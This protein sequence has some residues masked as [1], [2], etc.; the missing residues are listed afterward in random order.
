MRIT[1]FQHFLD[2]SGFLPRE[3][4][5]LRLA[6]QLARIIEAATCR[7]PGETAASAVACDRRPGRRA[8][9]GFIAVARWEVPQEIRW[10]CTVCGDAGQIMGWSDTTWDLRGQRVGRSESG[11]KRLE[12]SFDRRQYRGLLDLDHLDFDSHVLLCRACSTSKGISLAASREELEFLADDIVAAANHEFRPSWAQRFRAA[13]RAIE[14]VLVSGEA[15]GRPRRAGPARL[16]AVYRIHVRLQGVRPPVWRRLEVSAGSSLGVL[17][18]TIQSSLGWEDCHLH[19]FEIGD[20]RI[21]PQDEWSDP[22]LRDEDRV[23]IGDVLL[24]RGDSMLY[25]YDFGDDWRHTIELEDVVP[26]ASMETLPR[27]TDGRGEAPP[28][29]SGPAGRA[30]RASRRIDVAQVN[31]ALDWLCGRQR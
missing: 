10:E 3:G 24:R 27:C 28:E 20:Q 15:V 17:H 4:A 31:A 2:D 18:H 1:D 23:R 22:E 13:F 21:G 8:C 6:L 16:D 5:A 19:E 25:V 9:P 14:A 30:G 7:E 12:V 11:S 26:T 29:D